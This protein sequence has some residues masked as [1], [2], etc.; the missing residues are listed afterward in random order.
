MAR[1]AKVPPLAAAAGDRVG[2]APRAE[3]G[4]G[5]QQQDGVEVE[6][7]AG[8]L[9]VERHSLAVED[10]AVVHARA[11]GALLPRGGSGRGEAAGV[12][13]T[14]LHEPRLHNTPSA[15]GVL[16]GGGV[17]GRGRGVVWMTPESLNAP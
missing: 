17:G 15:G 8:V 9:E 10:D 14:R 5:E 12:H 16:A 1:H 3:R 7:D 4:G 11:G 2:R 13:A 6:A